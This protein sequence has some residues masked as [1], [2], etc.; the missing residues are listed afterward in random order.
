MRNARSPT[1]GVYAGDDYV[2]IVASQDQ[3][4]LLAIRD[5]GLTTVVE[6]DANVDPPTLSLTL[7]FGS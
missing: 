6:V 5:T 4:D 2:A 1:G 7:L 3:A